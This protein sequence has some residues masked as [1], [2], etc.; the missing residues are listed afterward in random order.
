MLRVVCRLSMRLVMML[1]VLVLAVYMVR[2]I[3]Y[4]VLVS[5]WL[6]SAE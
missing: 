2:V 1:L 4:M 6:A 5:L 3:S